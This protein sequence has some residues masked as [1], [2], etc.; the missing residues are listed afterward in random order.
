MKSSLHKQ[1]GIVSLFLIAM[2][3]CLEKVFDLTGNESSVR[4]ELL[5][6]LA[7]FFANIHLLII[8]PSLMSR[9]GIPLET[10]LIAYCLSTVVATTLQ[11][12]I[13]NSP[14][15]LGPGIGG[16]VFLARSFD[17]PNESVL[18]LCVA[19]TALIIMGLFRV[20]R[21]LYN[22]MPTCVK[23]G[24]PPGIGLYLSFC[25]VS[26]AGL[27]RTTQ[28]PVGVEIA[29]LDE[30]SL[31]II[32]GIVLMIVIFELN[33]SCPLNLGWLS[34]I[35]PVS[36]VCLGSWVLGLYSWPQG[37]I[38]DSFP[39]K[40]FVPTLHGVDFLKIL[41]KSVRLWLIM[42]F[43]I[44]GLSQSCCEL[45]GK[46]S[47][48][49]VSFITNS[50]YTVCGCCSFVAALLGT[51]PVIVFGES[52]VCVFA[53]GKT[54]LTS[55]TAAVCTLIA[56]TFA[57]I[58][59]AVPGIAVS[60][61]LIAVGWQLIHLLFL[62]LSSHD[63]VLEGNSDIIPLY[64][65]IAGMV[66]FDG[67]DIGIMCGLVMW[68]VLVTTKFVCKKFQPCTAVP[69]VSVQPVLSFNLCARVTQEGVPGL[70]HA[71]L[72]SWRSDRDVSTVQM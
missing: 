17:D 71:S 12:T 37:L 4:A 52:C 46:S 66:F 47:E 59:V 29:N 48:E 27:I 21:W 34:V 36:G 5:A 50:A 68:G 38:I 63:V 42:F 44:G 62:Q 58:F 69:M 51:G 25:G 1:L 64:C 72:R 2:R 20:P 41:Q 54:G 57:P 53:G 24:V 18:C 49:Q 15:F 32:L 33:A 19:S 70:Q 14:M 23:C 31:L 28:S 9:T 16:A 3:R 67:I 8:V 26:Q 61:P 30:S 45:T 65:T 7:G 43:D 22:N 39:L 35:L 56:L 55:C 60:L 10:G 6:G 13:A 40:L 11:S